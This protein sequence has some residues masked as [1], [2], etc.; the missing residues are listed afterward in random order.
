MNTFAIKMILTCCGAFEL[1]WS[2]LSNW[3]VITQR[4]PF[5]RDIS[6]ESIFI[7]KYNK[8]N[9]SGQLVDII[10][11]LNSVLFEF[12]RLCQCFY[13]FCLLQFFIHFAELDAWAPSA[14]MRPWRSCAL[15][16]CAT[17][18]MVRTG[19]GSIGWRPWCIYFRLFH[20][21]LFLSIFKTKIF[22]F[23]YSAIWR[24]NY[25]F[26]TMD[27]MYFNDNLT[28]IRL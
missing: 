22:V 17:R 25:S 5:L 11:K 8:Q 1:I 18:A 15:A 3:K 19:P 16:H 4:N 20:Q 21:I 10:L 24:F 6:F 27:L 2:N 23:N 9:M 14:L 13:F 26:T 28:I 7:Y 12:K